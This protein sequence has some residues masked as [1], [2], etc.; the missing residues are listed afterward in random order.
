M[1][2]SCRLSRASVSAAGTCAGVRR[3]LRFTACGSLPW[4]GRDDRHRPRCPGRPGG[5]AD[6]YVVGTLRRTSEGD[7]EVATLGPLAEPPSEEGLARPVFTPY[8]LQHR[9]ARC[10]LCPV[11]LR[12]PPRTAQIS[13]E[14]VESAL[15]DGATPEGVDHSRRRAALAE[16]VRSGR[17][18]LARSV[19]YPTP[20][21]GM[22]PDITRAS[23]HAGRSVDTWATAALQ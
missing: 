1:P 4:P 8:R 7:G 19:S 12:G 9:T 11:R 2:G 13:G 14:Q 21:A 16:Q 23:R 3:V 22:R 17:S 10:P 20:L 15:R 18:L 6:L 5:G